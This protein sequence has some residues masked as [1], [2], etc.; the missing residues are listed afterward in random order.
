MEANF[1]IYRT[2]VLQFDPAFTRGFVHFVASFPIKMDA[3]LT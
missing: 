3:V 1:A 2:A